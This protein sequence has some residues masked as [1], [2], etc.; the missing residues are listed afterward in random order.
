MAPTLYVNSTLLSSSMATIIND[1]VIINDD[2]NDD[3]GIDCSSGSSGFETFSLCNV[4]ISS[5]QFRATCL[6]IFMVKF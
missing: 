3:D 5:H 1:D 6:K 4:A 2:D